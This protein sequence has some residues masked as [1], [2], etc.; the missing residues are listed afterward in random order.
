MEQTISPE[1]FR[2]F[3]KHLKSAQD[4]L[5]EIRE[6]KDRLKDQVSKIKKYSVSKRIKQTTIEKELQVLEQ[7]IREVIN[8]E[9]RLLHG[10]DAIKVEMQ[11]KIANLE[12]EINKMEIELAQTKASSAK[13]DQLKDSI[14]ELR[15][16]IMEIEKK[17]D[18][19]EKRVEEFEEKI[20]ENVNKN[21]QE[22]L[23]IED[24]VRNLEEKYELV[25]KKGAHPGLLQRIEDRMKKLRRKTVEMKKKEV[26]KTEMPLPPMPT[27]K[28]SQDQERIFSEKEIEEGF[29]PTSK[30]MKQE[31]KLPELPPIEGI[32]RL[33]PPFPMPRHE[34]K[35][36]FDKEKP[37]EGMSEE[38]PALEQAGEINENFLESPPIPE[39]KKSFFEKMF[40]H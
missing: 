3:V 25:K 16:Q 29:S 23:K 22:I 20:K 11:E 26:I 38:L 30:M 18:E 5:Y 36:E 6:A 14:Q 32:E 4:K 40:S 37:L 10:Q 24:E 8:K 1:R 2:H 19:R 35:F 39:K 7:H 27:Y 15:N 31:M 33:E 12:K 34:L 9:R 28:K 21:L 17:R 13:T